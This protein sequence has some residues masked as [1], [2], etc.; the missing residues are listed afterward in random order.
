MHKL[1]TRNQFRNQVFERDNNLCV[2]C[3]K[4]AVDAHHILERR[5]FEDEGYYM[6]NGA[7][8]CSIH[9]LEAE[10]TILSAQK[11]R[12][13]IGVK[14][15]I[16]PDHLYVDQEY[17]KWGN[18]I[19]ENGKKLKGE[20]FQDESVQKI[21]KQGNVLDDFLDYIKYPRT[22]HLP[23]SGAKT[24]DDKTLKDTKH[25]EGKEVVV[26]LKMDGENTTMYNNYIHA[27]SIDSGNH[28]SRNY[29]KNIHGK[30]M[31]DIPEK[32]RICCENLYAK[33]S[34]EYNK[35]ESYAYIFSIWDQDN[36]CL[37]WDQTK[38]WSQLLNIPLVPILYEGLYDEKKI[39]ALISDK[40]QNEE[41][42][43]FVV[44]L[45]SDFSYRDFKKSVAKYVRTNHVHT[46]GHWMN[47]RVIPNKLKGQNDR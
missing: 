1:L 5:L 20:L 42:E 22:Y 38:E 18:I 27:R 44:R 14:K 37:S 41:M 35:L 10:M 16:L 3:K 13:L 11:I 39:K 34:I 47:Q 7:S 28:E 31:G 40:Y 8:L 19:L 43:G 30:I 15:P 4:P 24:K 36:R 25:F 26:T 21:L 23:F 32:W 12:E 17:D 46:H 45:K 6:D 33:H 2:V 9:H 29:V